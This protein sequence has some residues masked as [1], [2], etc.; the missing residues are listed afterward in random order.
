MNK[1]ITYIGSDHEVLNASIFENE[2]D[3]IER[4]EI[5]RMYPADG[6]MLLSDPSIPAPDTVEKEIYGIKDGKLVMLMKK[7]GVSYTNTKGQREVEYKTE[8]P[9][10]EL[11]E[12]DDISLANGRTY[13]KKIF[14]EEMEKYKKDIGTV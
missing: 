3:E 9:N 1:T 6:R 11:S 12:T 14:L 2:T 5:V 7:K 13:N 8:Y 10:V 4:I